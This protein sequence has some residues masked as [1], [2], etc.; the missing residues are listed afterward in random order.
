MKA[1]KALFGRRPAPVA[2]PIPVYAIGD[3]HGRRDLLVVLLERIRDHAAGAPAEIILLGDYVDRGPDSPG[4]IDCLLYSPLLDGFDRVFL[5]GNHEAT[6]LQFLD[7]PGVGPSWL[8]FGG[9]ETLLS[10]GVRPPALKGDAAAW[11]QASRD[12]AA[13][14]PG[15]HRRFLEQLSLTAVRGEYFF[16]H[17]GIDPERPLEAQTEA[18]LLWI[19]DA[20]LESAKRHDQIIVHG[21]SPQ[22]AP[23]RDHR[24][25][26]VD[27]GAYQ[28]GILTA[29][30]ISEAGVEFISTN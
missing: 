26:G 7:D 17:A 5:K 22:I 2:P 28:T 14:L 27:T 25:I 12:L 8:Q 20:F 29:A 10:Y 16:V 21:H 13:A 18:E 24:R 30:A 6:L 1:L 3:V 15:A 11:A 19:R 23:Y 9:G 4:V